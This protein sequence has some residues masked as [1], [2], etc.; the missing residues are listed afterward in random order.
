MAALLVNQGRPGEAMALYE[1]SRKQL[2]VICDGCDH[3]FCFDCG[4][5]PHRPAGCKDF[6]RW[7][8][9][10]GSSSFWIR[11]NA[12][13]CPSCA[14]PIEKASGCNH[15]RCQQC[16]ADWCWIC[17]RYLRS[18]MEAHVC[19]RYNGI[20][21]GEAEEEQRSIFFTD[22]YQ[23]HEEAESVAKQRADFIRYHEKEIK[24][25]LWYAKEHEIELYIL[26]FDLL[27]EARSFLKYSY[28]AA[29]SK[30][31]DAAKPFQRQ[32]AIL[33][34]ATEKLTQL[35]MSRLDDIYTFKGYPGIQLVFR[36]IYFHS[37][38]VRECIDR[39]NA[40]NQ[41]MEQDP[42]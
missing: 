2:A 13:P 12:K 25:G 8:Q 40:M 14:A 37:S 17:L 1:Q 19:N 30:H 22:R 11:K 29:W 21:D 5:L 3:T 35:T 23:A 24:E 26:A 20:T 39:L 31:D 36:S 33:E 32:Q 38:I 16:G 15:I 41:N 4:G 34:V 10:F 18:H 9:I 6:T 7:S 28:V 42:T 27:V